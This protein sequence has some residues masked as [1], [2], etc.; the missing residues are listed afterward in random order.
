MLITNI[1]NYFIGEAMKASILFCLMISMI[2]IGCAQQKR[3]PIEGAW[4]LVQS[5]GV[6]K[7]S[8]GNVIPV[9]F[10]PVSTKMWSESHFSFIG[11]WKQ[12]TTIRDFYGGGTYK[13]EGNRYE[14]NILY[15][16]IKSAIGQNVKM[17]LELRNDTLIQTYPVDSNGQI[18]KS[19]YYIEKYI[20]LK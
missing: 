3:I 11:Q 20:R 12:D 18:N 14:E 5:Q 1:S 19:D 6:T 15:H 7:D 10:H 17:L 8:L 16:F 2:I 4:Q 9:D 13:L